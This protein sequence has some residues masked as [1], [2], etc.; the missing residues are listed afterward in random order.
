MSQRRPNDKIPANRFPAS[1]YS[2][3]A[4]L[5]LRR[6]RETLR[7][8]NI[9]VEYAWRKQRHASIERSL[10]RAAMRLAAD[11]VHTPSTASDP[12]SSVP[13]MPDQVS[14]APTTRTHWT[15]VTK[16]QPT[17]GNRPPWVLPAKA[18]YGL[19]D[20]RRTIA[21]AGHPPV[22]F[23]DDLM[24]VSR[25]V[26]VR[27]VLA[28]ATLHARAFSTRRSAPWLAPG[29][30]TDA[31]DLSLF[32]LCTTSDASTRA[33]P[34]RRRSTTSSTAFGDRRAWI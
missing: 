33:K 11:P 32:A 10:G 30:A 31:A 9:D 6:N 24:A 18:A 14:T 13:S 7:A 29:H 17:L 21:R 2:Y 15:A 1:L 22:Q 4:F 12:S 23:P 26:I 5:D 27:L 34:S 25:T 16:H 8:Y 3:V 20:A 19:Y 28:F